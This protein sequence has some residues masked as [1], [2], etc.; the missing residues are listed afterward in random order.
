[1]FPVETNPATGQPLTAEYAKNRIRW[2]S[3]GEIRT[4]SPARSFGQRVMDFFL[5]LLPI[6]SQL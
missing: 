3:N 4:R 6:E 1:M 5:R 2:E